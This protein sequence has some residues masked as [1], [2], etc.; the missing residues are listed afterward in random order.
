MASIFYRSDGWVK[1]AIGQAAVGATVYV[2]APQPAN[3]TVPPTPLAVIYSDPGGLHPITQPV[4]A[5]GFGHYDFYAPAG[6]YTILIVVNNIIQEVL[7]DQPVGGGGAFTPGG[8]PGQVQGN[9]TGSFAGIPGS[10]IDF[11]NGPL[12]LAPTGAGIALSLVG[13]SGVALSVK[14]DSAGSDIQDWYVSGGSTPIDYIDSVGNLHLG[15]FIYDSN[16][17]AGVVGN[18]MMVGTN[19]VVWSN[20]TSAINYVIDGGGIGIGTGAKGQLNIPMACTITGW[21]LTADQSGSAVV[22][23][24]TSTYAGFPATSSI[25]STDKPTLS[26][27]QKNENLAVSVWT[28]AIAAGTQLQFNVN[29]ATTV[30]RLNLTINITLNG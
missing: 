26:S 20:R 5:D 24:L 25:A 13:N 15:K 17:S 16:G 2:C 8:V 21:V 23:V 18:V 30:T 12:I 10:L 28:T 11:L 29:S 7:V 6:I 27:A 22:D 3:L 9:N 1:S 14:G 19:G 4:V